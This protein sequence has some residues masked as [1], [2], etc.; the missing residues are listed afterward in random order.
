M[1]KNMKMAISF[2]DTKIKYIKKMLQK[3][4]FSSFL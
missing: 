2:I 1:R 3:Q 4:V